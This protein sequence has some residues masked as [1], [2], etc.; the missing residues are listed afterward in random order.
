VSM[1]KIAHCITGLQKDGAQRMLYRLTKGMDR[2]RFENLVISLRREEPFAEEFRAEGIKLQCVGM[3]AGVPGPLAIFRLA[4][5][6]RDFKPDLLQGWMYHANLALTFSEVVARTK[7]P[8]LWNIRRS[9][10]N[11]SGDKLLTRA[12]VK[13]SAALSRTAYR[14]VYCAEASAVQHEAI[15]FDP[16]KRIVL[17][18]GFNTDLFAPS[19]EC[20]G[21]VRKELN[22]PQAARIVGIIGRYHPQKDHHSFLR[23]AAMVAEK[24][25]DVYFVLIGRGLEEGNTAVMRDVTEGKLS[26]RVRLLGERSSVNGLLPAFDVYCSSSCNEGFPNV[27][28]EAMSCGVPC[29]VTDVGASREIVGDTGVVVPPTSPEKLAQGL[30]TLLMLT[31]E[32]WTERSSTARGRVL[33]LFSMS[34]IVRQYEELYTS[35]S[36][37]S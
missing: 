27:V 6:L 23:A 21:S 36:E 37:R 14:I 33:D 8:V 28:G 19:A 26:A 18:N 3:T 17:G 11:Q 9:L 35:L 16:T 31:R 24:H 10:H 30:N 1:I 20:Y 5:I 22:I 12:V 25:P 13:T 15:G 7:A 29:V 34:A 2:S 32:E 4:K